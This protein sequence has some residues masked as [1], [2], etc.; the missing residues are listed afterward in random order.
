MS[1]YYVKFKINLLHDGN[2]FQN[3]TE[4][5]A[6]TRVGKTVYL[7]IGSGTSFLAKHG[8]EFILFGEKAVYLKNLIVESGLANVEIV[9]EK[10]SFNFENYSIKFSSASDPIFG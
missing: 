3:P 8:D 5:A 2:Y 6:L 4:V 9:A 1:S 7:P 10:N